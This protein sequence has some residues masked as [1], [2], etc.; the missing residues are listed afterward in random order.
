MATGRPTDPSW[1]DEIDHATAPVV[2]VRPPGRHERRA[3]FRDGLAVAALV[4]V[5]GFGSGLIVLR[6]GGA[7]DP[8]PA[9]SGA[10]ASPGPVAAATTGPASGAPAPTF[11]PPPIPPLTL[12]YV[13]D[14][15]LPAGTEMVDG[16]GF[17]FDL[18]TDPGARTWQTCPGA[19]GPTGP[20][21][22]LRAVPGAHV[23]IENSGF[24][25]S[26]RASSPAVAC[27]HLVG[28][29]G[30]FIEDPSC[31][32]GYSAGTSYAFGF[33][34]PDARGRWVIAVRGC[35]PGLVTECGAWYA[36]VDTFDATPA[37]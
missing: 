12:V 30:A 18:A 17:E 2:A 32:P 26:V 37:A 21:G 16:C 3:G 25:P 23:L 6:G 22:V 14:H 19:E 27:G 15:G 1:R 10:E 11:D 8:S 9:P 24:T 13:P 20:L 29:P 31:R 33:S 36:E 7:M 34:L 28:E 5:L 35:L 4:V